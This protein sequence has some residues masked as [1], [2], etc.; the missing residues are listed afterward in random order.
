MLQRAIKELTKC[1][2]TIRAVGAEKQELNLI[3]N[4]KT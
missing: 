2:K 4:N 3:V 1:T